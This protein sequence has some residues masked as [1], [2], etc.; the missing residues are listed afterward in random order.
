MAKEKEKPKSNYRP[1]KE[2]RFGLGVQSQLTQ[3][4]DPHKDFIKPE[5][6]NRISEPDKLLSESATQLSEPD[7]LL[8]AQ[9]S[10]I[11]KPDQEKAHSDIR[12]SA[13]PDI[14]LPDEPSLSP[15]TQ[16]EYSWKSRTGKVQLNTRISE[17]LYDQVLN[18]AYLLSADMKE[19]VTEALC[20][21]VLK[22]SGIR[23]S[24]YPDSQLAA[25][26]QAPIKE[27]SK[28]EIINLYSQI[29]KKPVGIRDRKLIDKAL[30]AFHPLLIEFG[31]RNADI[32]ARES[33]GSVYSFNYCMGQI[34]IYADWDLS[35]IAKELAALR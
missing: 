9:D 11:A 30:K 31:I 21:I 14:L 34:S 26:P 6:D 24:A 28:L 13:Y 18:V 33:G 29:S 32:A 23:I 12:L 4:G 2:K 1:V 25:Y 5:E 15:A 22:Y 3:I 20:D 17:N 27:L 35:A 7:K 16:Y 8:S 19:I 10:R